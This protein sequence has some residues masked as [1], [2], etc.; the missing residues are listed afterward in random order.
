M[1]LHANAKRDSDN[2][3]AA[4]LAPAEITNALKPKVW[5]QAITEATLK[6]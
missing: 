3:A 4:E 1:A 2:H 6:V 5:M